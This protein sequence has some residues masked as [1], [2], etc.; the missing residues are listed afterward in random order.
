M[1][2]VAVA[3]H[4]ITYSQYVFNNLIVNPAYAGYK[5]AY[6]VSML[7]RNQWVG[8]KGAPTTQ[9]LIA[10]GAFTKNNNV[11]L[12]LTVLKDKVGIQGQTSVMANYAYRLPINS[13]SR[14][15]FGIGLGA[16]Q[17]SVNG[18]DAVT[19][20]GSDPN[21][22]GEDSFTSPDAR[23]GIY[24]NTSKFYVGLSANN[25]LSRALHKNNQQ[26]AFVI[27]PKAHLFITAG[28]IFNVKEGIKFKPS[29][30]L[31]DSP[32]GMGNFDVNTSFLLKEMLTL[33]A[34]YRV[35]VDV[36]KK[37]VGVREAFQQNSMVALMEVLI[38]KQFRFG[39]AY[40]YSL[41]KINTYTSGSHEFSLGI[42]IG[43]KNYNDGALTSPR[44]F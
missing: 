31:R 14:L 32:D 1:P 38:A 2:A 41:S 30:M 24:L 29:L 33:G 17:Y 18:N 13:E 5:E 3:Q 10:D 40:D 23:L 8:V 21:F 35:G 15:S 26:A 28:S 34:S 39:Y 37:S 22:A 6:N 19:G 12:G 16:T 4:E 9:S 42:I 43:K 25:L 27:L 11:G 7:N 44:Y 36:L 20:D